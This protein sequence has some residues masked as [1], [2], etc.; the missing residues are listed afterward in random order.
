[1]HRYLYGPAVDQVLV[2]EVFDA[3]R[4]QSGHDEVLWLL[5]DQQG[6]IRDVV[7]DTA[8]AAEAH[9]LRLVRQDHRRAVL[10]RG[11]AAI[12]AIARRS[13]RPTVLL[14]GQERDAATGLQLHGPLV[15]PAIG[16]LM[17]EDPSA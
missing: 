17:S 13:G 14:P 3:G 10:R 12:P 16:R 8:R 1:M 7:D 11:T 5:G 9:R 4:G 15:R 2:D 6:T